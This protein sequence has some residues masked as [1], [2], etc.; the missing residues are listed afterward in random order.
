MADGWAILPR[1]M[2]STAQPNVPPRSGIV[3]TVDTQKTRGSDPVTQFRL[4]VGPL[5]IGNGWV[6]GTAAWRDCTQGYKSIPRLC[7]VVSLC[8]RSDESESWFPLQRKQR[9]FNS[10]PESA[11]LA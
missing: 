6:L 10:G 1:G 9:C 4:S 8:P 3:D 2:Q 5:S 11:T 7:V